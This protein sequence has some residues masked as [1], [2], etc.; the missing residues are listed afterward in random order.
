MITFETRTVDG[1]ATVIGPTGRLDMLAA[2]ELKDRVNDALAGGGKPIVVDLG[3]VS[4]IDSTG[5]GALVSGLRA[6]RQ[7][8]SDLRIARA[9]K[10]VLTVL[11]ITRID[12]I[13]RPYPT[14][15]EAIS[16]L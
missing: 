5:L 8:G 2:R 12:R 1:G 14:I 11:Q 3:E 9:T 15:E 7:V 4:F 6:A 13:I 10:Q 16:V